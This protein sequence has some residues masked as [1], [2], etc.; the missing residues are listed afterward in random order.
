[1][2]Q[3]YCSSET[4]ASQSCFPQQSEAWKSKR[5]IIWICCLSILIKWCFNLFR[6][7]IFIY[8]F[9]FKSYSHYT[10]T[11]NKKTSGNLLIKPAKTC[12]FWAS[13]ATLIRLKIWHLFKRNKVSVEQSERYETLKLNKHQIQIN[14]GQKSLAAMW[15]SNNLNERYKKNCIHCGCTEVL[16]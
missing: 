1:M 9:H 8:F 15:R 5:G 2:L 7:T 14:E 4:I 16:A 12:P 13:K 6:I 3:D 10:I 11:Q